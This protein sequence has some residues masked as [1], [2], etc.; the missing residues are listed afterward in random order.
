MEKEEDVIAVDVDVEN[1]FAHIEKKKHDVDMENEA[2]KEYG[3]KNI[4][5]HTLA[6]RREY[7]NGRLSTI[8]MENCSSAKTNYAN[9]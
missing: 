3:A 2:E 7:E 9:K 6:T 4:K 8:T 5:M 1:C